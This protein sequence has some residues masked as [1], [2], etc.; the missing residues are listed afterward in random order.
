MMAPS[1]APET[2]HLPL[3]EA[4]SAGRLDR[5]STYTNASET[6]RRHLAH[7]EDHAHLLR[8][9]RAPQRRSSLQHC[10]TR[11]SEPKVPEAPLALHTE[12]SHVAETPQAHTPAPEPPLDSTLGSPDVRYL[13]Q[14][15]KDTQK[16]SRMSL[17]VLECLVY[18]LD[19]L[20]CP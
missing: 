4:K 16:H 9:A 3:P 2:P 15:L 5:Q 6:F 11:D 10:L 18:I 17:S 20:E 12:S 1:R 14:T 13:N 8:Q 7:G 19:N